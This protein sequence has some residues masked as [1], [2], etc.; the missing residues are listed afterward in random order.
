MADGNQNGADE[1]GGGRA[2]VDR[3]MV[4]R[5]VGPAE[6]AVLGRNPY[7]SMIRIAVALIGFIV[8]GGLLFVA[9][10]RAI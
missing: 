1:D 5:A 8:L 3:E 9:L 2:E 4:D 7:G 10:I 6:R